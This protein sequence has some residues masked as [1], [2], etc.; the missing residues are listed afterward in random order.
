[1]VK[2]SKKVKTPVLEGGWNFSGRNWSPTTFAYNSLLNGLTEN[3]RSNITPS[4]VG[5]DISRNIKDAISF[6]KNPNIEANTLDRIQGQASRYGK[7]RGK[8]GGKLRAS[9]VRN[10]LDASYAEEPPEKI[11]DYILDNGLSNQ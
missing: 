11:G 3:Y 5:E 4:G 6:A 1:M 10:L 9:E 8:K 7:G 2:K